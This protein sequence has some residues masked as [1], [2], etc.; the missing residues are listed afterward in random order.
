[1][2][3]FP[4]LDGVRLQKASLAVGSFDGVHRGHQHLVRSMVAE[5]HAQGGTPTVLTFFPHPSVVL[6]RRSS[7]LYL[8]TPQERAALL[9]KLGVEVVITHPFTLEFSHTSAA[10]IISRLVAD[11]GM[12]SLWAGMD[13]ALGHNREGGREYLARAGAQLGFEVHIV[14]PLIEDGTPISSTRIR[15]ALSEGDMA[16]VSRCL[17][18]PFALTGQ[19]VHG[20]QRGAS[21]GFPTANVAVWEARAVP[22]RGV[23]A[24][25]AEVGARHLPSVTNIGVRPTF[26]GQPE[27]QVVETHILDFDEDLYGQPL[28][29]S[30][31]ARLRA[32]TKFA[33][34]EAL[35]QQIRADIEQTRTLLR[36]AS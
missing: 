23:Y 34:V 5:A 33:G 14:D 18:R 19:V 28:T 10:D 21:L 16:E 12:R 9:A 17:G 11:L 31:V 8:T 32:E 13:F 6:G 27:G 25:W 2:Q 3:H 22:A 35:L 36:S 20:A 15:L 1:M 26:A 4:T 30:F 29:V 7:T 24:T